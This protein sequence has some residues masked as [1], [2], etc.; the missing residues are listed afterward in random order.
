MHVSRN[1]LV[2]VQPEPFGKC[3]IMANKCSANQDLEGIFD[4]LEHAYKYFGV[5]TSEKDC[6]VRAQSYWNLCK[7]G[8]HEPIL[9]RF[10]PTGALS[11]Y[12]DEDCVDKYSKISYQFYSHYN[13][14]H[15]QI[16]KNQSEKVGMPIRQINSLVACMNV[17][18]IRL[19]LRLTPSASPPPFYTFLFHLEQNDM[20]PSEPLGKS[21]LRWS[22]DSITHYYWHSY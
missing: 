1:D 17:F 21:N 19:P 22:A 2:G 12:P 14:G 5:G 13:L 11:S 3:W 8:P 18:I 6:L 7:N 20:L 15:R 16:M 10:L 4:D 9:V